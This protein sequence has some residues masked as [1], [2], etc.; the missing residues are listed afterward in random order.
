MKNH[1][2]PGLDLLHTTRQHFL[3]SSIDKVKTSFSQLLL[4][5]CL[6]R[7][8]GLA[9]AAPLNLLNLSFKKLKN[10][11]F[12][13]AGSLIQFPSTI[14][15]VN[16]FYCLCCFTKRWKNFEF[17]SPSTS[18]FFL[19]FWASSNRCIFSTSKSFFFVSI[20]VSIIS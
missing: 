7:A 11:F 8:L 1:L 16:V 12:T 10:R 9:I 15:P 6:Y 18:H 19:S 4:D 13:S 3:I 17:S 20:L 2:D 5:K 14:M